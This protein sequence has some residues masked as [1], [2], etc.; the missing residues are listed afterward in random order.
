MEGSHRLIGAID[1]VAITVSDLERLCAFYTRVLG[2][3]TDHEYRHDGKLAV[4]Q[5]SFGDVKISVHQ[6]GNGVGLVA[7]RPT[8]GAADLC[9]MWRGTITQAAAFLASHGVPIVEGPAPRKTR[10]GRAAS[11]LYCRDPDGNLLELMAED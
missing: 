5:V 3:R 8:Q 7:A 1:H 10:D 9:F 6:A 2:A 11:S 4:R